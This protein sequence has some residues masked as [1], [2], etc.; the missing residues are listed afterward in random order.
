MATVYK[1]LGQSA[2]GATTNTNLY[3]VPA[4]TS[5]VVSTIVVANRAAI[6]SNYR[7]AI[8]PA[9]AT[10]ANQHYLAYDVAVGGADSTTLTLGITL[11]ATDVVTI[12]ASS[13]N[14][15]FSLFGSEITA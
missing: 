8:R 12:Y 9:G 10:I 4:D 5:A 14:L 7:I 6:S 11:A 15:S 3:T 13:A 1:V 2:P